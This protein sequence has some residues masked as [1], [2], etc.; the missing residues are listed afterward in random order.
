MTSPFKH[1]MPAPGDIG[2]V[3][4]KGDVG[5]MIQLGQ[6]LNGDGSSGFSH[7]FVYVG[8][9]QI[10]EAEPGGAKIT[11]IHYPESEVH[12][13]T[14]IG[15]LWTTEARIKVLS[16]AYAY[17]GVPYSAA[18]YFA[19]AAKRLHVDPAGLLKD[20]VADSRHMICSQLADQ[21]AF[22]CGVKIFDD[23]RWPGYVTPGSLYERDLQLLHA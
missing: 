2:L 20:Y 14:G 12:W 17:R 8:G 21:V 3:P 4:V 22:D 5:R 15:R 19:L 10:I 1:Y 11:G 7:A 13:C 23:G 18:D 6:F 9:H 16:C